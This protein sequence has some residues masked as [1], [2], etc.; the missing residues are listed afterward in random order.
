MKHLGSVAFLGEATTQHRAN[1]KDATRQGVQ[2]G[3]MPWF[4]SLALRYEHPLDGVALLTFEGFEGCWS[5]FLDGLKRSL[6]ME[7]EKVPTM[8][9]SIFTAEQ[10]AAH[11]SQAP[12]VVN[13]TGLYTILQLFSSDS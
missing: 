11:I 4:L 7:H 9:T 8:K 3:R 10:E 2:G 13:E 5:W 1:G 12:V 6:A